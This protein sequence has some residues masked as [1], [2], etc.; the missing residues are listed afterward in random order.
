MFTL[1]HLCVLHPIAIAHPTCVFSSL[2]NDMH[3]VCHALDVL[4]VFL[5]LQ[6]EFGTLGFFIQ[7]T[8]CVA[9]SPQ[10]LD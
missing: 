4:L 5:R 2:A 9:W 3:V 1:I 7:P 6:E 8:K 10:G